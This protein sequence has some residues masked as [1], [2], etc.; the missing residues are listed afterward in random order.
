MV[1]LND[2]CLYPLSHLTGSVLGFLTCPLN[3]PQLLPRFQPCSHVHYLSIMCASLHCWTCLF[4][5]L[6]LKAFS[7]SSVLLHSEATLLLA[8]LGFSPSN[9][10]T[11]VLEIPYHLF[12]NFD[13]IS[14]CSPGCS[15]H[16]VGHAASK[17]L[18]LRLITQKREP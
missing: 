11:L 10:N 14:L 7:F 17:F 8:Y 1:R 4:S 13:R 6:N 18:K 5:Y 9:T 3:R 16:F 2:K 15:T 12:L